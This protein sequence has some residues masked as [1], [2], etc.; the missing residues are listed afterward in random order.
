MN[1]IFNLITAGSLLAAL[2]IAQPAPR[3]K[4]VDLGTLGGAGTNSSAYDMN[5]SGWVAGSGNLIPGGPQ[6]GIVWFGSRPS[7]DL[8]T[9]DGAA[10]PDCNSGAASPNARGDTPVG[11]ETSRLDPNGEDFCAYGTHRQCRAAIWRAGKMTAL[12]NLPGGNNA[13]PFGINNRGQVIGF[14]ENGLSDP[15]C[16]TATPFQVTRFDAVIWE[17]G[18]GIRSLTP[19]LEMGD[20][21]TFAFGINDSGQAVGSSGTCSTQG[22]PPANVTGLHAVLWEK[23]GTP[24]YLGNLGGTANTMFNAA[25]SVNSFGD[26]VGTSQFTDGTIHSFLWT[27]N[28]G[29]R[30]I[31]TLPGAV[32]TIVP[33]CN[34]LNNK[35][36]AVGFSI[37]G[38]NFGSRAFLWQNKVITD[39][40]TLI[41]A[42]SP[43]NL[44]GAFSINDAGQIVGQGA[45]N[46]ELRA[47]LAIPIP[48]DQH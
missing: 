4:V 17:P 43:W 9:L 33:C 5:N 3:Y 23:D 37:D 27:R 20:T 47:F 28:S 13:N 32:V 35:G 21:V 44:L 46:G 16:A 26:V 38:A 1:P 12:P 31:G 48:A 14:A 6:H 40:N 10:C 19:L 11:S 45:I 30:D 7:I 22:L 15:T 2:S 8:G 36:Q 42:G 34:T 39:L 41:P 18:G 29:M 25:T 24:T